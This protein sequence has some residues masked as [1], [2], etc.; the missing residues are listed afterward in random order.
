MLLGERRDRGGQDTAGNSDSSLSGVNATG[1][2]SIDSGATWRLSD[3]RGI[4]NVTASLYLLYFVRD[5]I[6]A[7]SME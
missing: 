4:L 5:T 2:C 7:T 6:W 1:Y 3:Q